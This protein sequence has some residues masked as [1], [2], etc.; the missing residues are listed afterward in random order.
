MI[1]EIEYYKGDIL[2]LGKR[3]SQDQLQKELEE[4]EKI[5]NKNED[6]FIEFLCKKYVWVM[7]DKTENPE[8]TYDRDIGKLVANKY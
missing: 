4:V 1:I 6:N 2:L 8:Y 3:R 7:I 5:Y